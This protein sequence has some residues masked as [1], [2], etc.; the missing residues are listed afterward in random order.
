M[1][2]R[3]IRLIL[4]FTCGLLVGVCAA[5]AGSRSFEV[6]AQ[7]NT[8][9]LQ[10]DPQVDRSD[11]GSK[12]ITTRVVM[13]SVM[14]DGAVVKQKETGMSDVPVNFTLPVGVYDVR[15][16]GDGVSTV[17]K[18]GVNVTP[19]DSTNLLPAMRAGQGVCECRFSK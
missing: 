2:S 7:Q 1:N 16:E 17:M 19:N 18:R 14:K 3:S 9:N 5:S 13:V 11:S 15:V 10:V 6:F 8:G 4:I 12:E